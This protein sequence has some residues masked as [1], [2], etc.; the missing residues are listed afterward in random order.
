MVDDFVKSIIIIVITKKKQKK[1]VFLIVLVVVNLVGDLHIVQ[2]DTKNINNNVVVFK[3]INYNNNMISGTK[4]Y[5][6]VASNL[7]D[8]KKNNQIEKTEKTDKNKEKTFAITNAHNNSDNIVIDLNVGGIIYQTLL[9]TLKKNPTSRLHDMFTDENILKLPKDKNG[10]Y[11]ID[12]DGHVFHYILEFLRDDS[13]VDEKIKKIN[14]LEI[15]SDKDGYD[16]EKI[17]NEF[18][19]FCLI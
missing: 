10:K 8:S 9:S 14:Q 12:R 13:D 2:Q 5:A 6:D 1:V 19:Y 15:F 4:S 18:V 17:K 7:K 3:N 16:S 11:F